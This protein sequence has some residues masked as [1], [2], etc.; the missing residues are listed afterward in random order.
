MVDST[1]T[2]PPFRILRYA[3]RGEDIIVLGANANLATVSDAVNR[4]LLIRRATGDTAA[5][6]GEVRVYLNPTPDSAPPLP[7]AERV[8]ND[9][10][11]ADRSEVPHI[12]RERVVRIWLPAQRPVQHLQP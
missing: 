10:L 2:A 4:L 5:V 1:M 11:A 3:G 7:W 9:L 12:G 8:L 6:D